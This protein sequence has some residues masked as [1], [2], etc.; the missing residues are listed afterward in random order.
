[1]RPLPRPYGGPLAPRTDVPGLPAPPAQIS[2]AAV[3]A[4]AG[5][6]E[7]LGDGGD[8]VQGVRAFG[9]FSVVS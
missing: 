9:L 1:M 2:A 5:G 7:E 4:R 3:S 8:H 6:D